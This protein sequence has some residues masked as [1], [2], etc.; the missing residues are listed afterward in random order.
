[1]EQ[2]PLGSAPAAFASRIRAERDRWGPIVDATGYRV[3]E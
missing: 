2:T 3:E 1:M